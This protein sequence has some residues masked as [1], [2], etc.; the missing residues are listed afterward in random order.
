MMYLAID[1]DGVPHSVWGDEHQAIRAIVPYG[2]Y[3][4]SQSYDDPHSG[5]GRLA[6]R[7]QSTY[8]DPEDGLLTVQIYGWVTPVEHEPDNSVGARGVW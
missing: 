8:R 5:H 1:P 7:L 4:H 2:A 6:I 3:L